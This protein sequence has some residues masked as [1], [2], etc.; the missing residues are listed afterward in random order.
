MLAENCRAIVFRSALAA[1]SEAAGELAFRIVG[2]GDEG[3]VAPPAQRQAPLSASGTEA[4]IAA[5]AFVREQE[6]REELVERRGDLRRLLLHDLGGLGLEVAPAGFE[7]LLP[8]RPAAGDVVQLV[9]AMDRE[10]LRSDERREGKDCV[11][12]LIY[13]W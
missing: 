13:Q 10:I 4:R 9:L 7:H 8:L 6:R 11:S 12:A 3:P 2:A 5:V 1:L